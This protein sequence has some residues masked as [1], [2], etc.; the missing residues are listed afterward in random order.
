VEKRRF[1]KKEPGRYGGKDG[2]S[3]YIAYEGRVYDASRNFLWQ[4]DVHQALHVAGVELTRSLD[5]APHDA[6]VLDRFPMVGTLEG[7]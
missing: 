5:E 7:K 3:T 2:T 6:S 1:T 4:N